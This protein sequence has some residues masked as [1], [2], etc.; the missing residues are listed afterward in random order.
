MQNE[1]NYNKKCREKEENIS[2]EEEQD[3]VANREFKVNI[4][5]R[6][7]MD[8]ERKGTSKEFGIR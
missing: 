7:R 2:R 6:E 5:V 4:R 1:R 8:A 3:R